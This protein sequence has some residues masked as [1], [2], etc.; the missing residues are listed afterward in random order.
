MKKYQEKVENRAFMY[1]QDRQERIK[2]AREEV[3]RRREEQERLR[4]EEEVKEP[5]RLD[6]ENKAT[7]KIDNLREILNKIDENVYETE[8]AKMDS[9][10]KDLENNKKV[11]HN[12]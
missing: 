3:R 10:K 8:K 4:R 11:K 2:R 12:Y 9:E 6:N 7:E 1:D 5:I